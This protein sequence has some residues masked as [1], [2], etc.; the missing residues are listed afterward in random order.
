M[1][2]KKFISGSSATYSLLP[3]DGSGHS[4]RWLRTDANVGFQPFA[5]TSE[6]CN[7]DKLPSRRVAHESDAEPGSND[8]ADSENEEYDYDRHLRVI[9]A[10]PAA[11]FFPASK[12]NSLDLQPTT[13]TE[14]S[15]RK[16]CTD[17]IKENIDHSE[18]EEVFDV[19]EHARAT[20]DVDEFDDFFDGIIS[21]SVNM[22][23]DNKPPELRTQL[24]SKITELRR[25][26]P[27]N[28]GSD[29]VFDSIIRYYDAPSIS[30]SGSRDDDGVLKLLDDLEMNDSKTKAVGTVSDLE[31][32]E[33][34]DHAPKSVNDR[35]A[36]KAKPSSSFRS[37][38]DC[39]TVIS[40]FSAFDNHPKVLLSRREKTHCT[41]NISKSTTVEAGTSITS[42]ATSRNSERFD[43]HKAASN[44]QI[45]DDGP[46]WRQN[47]CRKGESK[48]EKKVR[49]A[50]VKAGR[51]QARLDKKYVKDA[52]KQAEKANASNS[53][54][55]SLLNVSLRGLE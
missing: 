37:N 40:T 32:L 35:E 26:T 49:K 25:S 3:G 33:L 46:K 21:T 17:K 23:P 15:T 38:W 13:S 19:M 16:E 11:T 7:E 55:H 9:G 36:L 47:I 24:A 28:D 29:D 39:Q 30:S 6:T 20:R 5:V 27:L 22:L 44:V 42:C 43:D 31:E 52:F 53:K 50:A 10:D 51:R 18:V 14:R 54:D 41:E 34:S 8:V 45:Y 2:K 48:E 4:M 12:G 1:P